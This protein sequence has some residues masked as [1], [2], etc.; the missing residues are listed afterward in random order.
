MM[1]WL[2]LAGTVAPYVLYVRSLGFISASRVGTL[3]LAEPLTA[4]ALGILLLSEAPSLRAG[5]GGALVF[6]AL[7]FLTIERAQRTVPPEEEGPRWSI[8]TRG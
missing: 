6:A 7:A 3:A 1:T 5:I 4:T 8:P 2:V